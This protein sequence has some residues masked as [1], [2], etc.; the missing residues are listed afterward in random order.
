[1]ALPTLSDNNNTIESMDKKL[2]HINDNS[3]TLNIGFQ[4]IVSIQQA[5]TVAI[6]EL[7]G[8]I[9]E[10]LATSF[11]L[12]QTEMQERRIALQRAKA[13][14]QDERKGMEA[15]TAKELKEEA[16]SS[17][18]SFISVALGAIT[19]SALAPFAVW[20]ST[21]LDI[22]K[23][24]IGGLTKILDKLGLGPA[25]QRVQEAFSSLENVASTINSKSIQMVNKIA[26]FFSIPKDLFDDFGNKTDD[27]VKRFPGFFGKIN[28]AFDFLKGYAKGLF[29][30]FFKTLNFAFFGL[31]RLLRRIPFIGQIIDFAIGIFQ[32][33]KEGLSGIDLLFSGITGIFA[34]GIGGTTDLI[35]DSLNWVLGLFG[36]DLKKSL[37]LKKD[38]SLQKVIRDLFFDTFDLFK[39][40][41]FKTVLGAFDKTVQD[42][43]KKIDPALDF[44]K[45]NWNAF[46]MGLEF[47]T[48][49]DFSKKWEELNKS[50]EVAWNN[51][52]K[53]FSGFWDGLK[54]WISGKWTLLKLGLETGW[55]NFKT[56]FM[57]WW[58][59]DTG[60][61][62]WISGKWND[63]T[64]FLDEKWKLIKKSFNLDTILNPIVEGIT[65]FFG[66]F[67]FDNIKKLLLKIAEEGGGDKIPYMMDFLRSQLGVDDSKNIPA[68]T[69][70]NFSDKMKEAFSMMPAQE[71]YNEGLKMIRDQN[72]SADK[73]GELV[74]QLREMR[75]RASVEGTFKSKRITDSLQNAQTKNDAGKEQK[76]E[77]ASQIN[78][79]QVDQSKKSD[80]KIIQ[81]SNDAEYLP[82]ASN[83]GYVGRLLQ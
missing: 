24:F 72:L 48:G 51:F 45:R 74:S 35:V 12:S 38:F 69:L 66:I 79:T 16:S 32:G 62:K 70:D 65:N 14:S 61:T 43:T 37:G 33:F 5:S 19:A 78:N 10:T 50:I 53:T 18:F 15:V 8:G 63:L 57:E 36:F 44:F 64:I 55:T 31:F 58:N 1:M 60:F 26:D 20:L 6:V 2:G 80:I 46:V 11:E 56:G 9:L 47:M 34:G 41:D 22:I 67:S 21:R 27:L 49:M 52:S 42:V 3:E 77:I 82:D 13:E 25:L 17:L 71:A 40:L 81:R 4:K 75:K 7:L 73:T 68:E 30:V 23:G 83:R 39:K 59:A 28:A 54:T 29:G 76:Q